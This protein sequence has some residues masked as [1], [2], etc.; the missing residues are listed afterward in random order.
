MNDSLLNKFSYLS[1]MLCL[2][3]FQSCAEERP[4]VPPPSAEYVVTVDS[5]G[6]P[7]NISLERFFRQKE[8]APGVKVMVIDK[9]N[10]TPKLIT[11]AELLTQNPNAGPYLIFKHDDPLR[12]FDD[13][14]L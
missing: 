12:P 13:L 11:P 1:L 5:L 9:K 8:H 3:M 14:P 4:T 10:N 7:S 2:M 6:K